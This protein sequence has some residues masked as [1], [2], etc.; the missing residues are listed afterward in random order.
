MAFLA[1][2]SAIL[3]VVASQHIPEPGTYPEVPPVYPQPKPPVYQPPPVEYPKDS[4]PAYPPE[5]GPVTVVP[6][7]VDEWGY[8]NDPMSKFRYN[9]LYRIQ[10]QKSKLASLIE[11]RDLT[12][13]SIEKISSLT[14]AWCRSKYRHTAQLVISFAVLV[15]FTQNL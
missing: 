6:P 13:V 9:V 7:Y 8:D 10:Q 15:L 3:A 14:A 11:F 5:P 4:P 12:L 1:V 2:F